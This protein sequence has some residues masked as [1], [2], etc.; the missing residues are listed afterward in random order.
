MEIERSDIMRRSINSAEGYQPR[1]RCASS[2]FLKEKTAPKAVLL[3]QR[4]PCQ[5]GGGNLSDAVTD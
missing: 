4:D 2:A 1:G 3:K 5:E